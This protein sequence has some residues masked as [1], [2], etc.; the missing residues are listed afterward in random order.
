MDFVGH[1]A[2]CAGFSKVK[3]GTHSKTGEKVALKLLHTSKLAMNESSKKQVEA[4][5]LAM[6]KVK[7]PHV[8]RL[9]HVDWQARYTKKNGKNILPESIASK[10]TLGTTQDVMLVVLELATGGELFE[11]LQHTG[12]HSS[13]CA[14]SLPFQVPSRRQW[15]VPTSTN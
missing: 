1:L 5:I 11:F 3:L 7:H 15:L 14:F 2:C 4:E 13:S 10:L 9:K 8:I 12:S 6:S